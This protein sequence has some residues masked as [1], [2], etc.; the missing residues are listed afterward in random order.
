MSAFLGEGIMCFLLATVCK[1][2]DLS[3]RTDLKHHFEIEFELFRFKL[4]FSVLCLY[5]VI[6]DTG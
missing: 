1:E 4:S 6:P 5:Y 3:V 2:H